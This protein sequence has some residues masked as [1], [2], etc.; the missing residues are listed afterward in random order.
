MRA[1]I[2]GEVRVVSFYVQVKDKRETPK[3]GPA[4]ASSKPV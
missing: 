2:H 1:I 3:G 4:S